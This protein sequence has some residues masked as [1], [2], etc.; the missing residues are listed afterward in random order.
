MVHLLPLPGS[1][2]FAGSFENAV[3]TAEADARTLVEAGFPAL[4]VENFGDAPFH[5]DSVPPVTIAAMTRAVSRIV[6]MGVTVGVNVLRNDAH[7]A[8]GIA[9]ATGAR[10][11]RVN[12]LTGLMY[13]DQGPIVGRAAELQRS[14]MSLAPDVEVW[15]DVMVKHASPPPGADI[16][17]TALDT[18][19]RGLADAVIVSGAGTSSALD[20]EEAALVKDSVPAGTRIVAGS[21]V[22]SSNLDGMLGSIDT[23]IVGS[24]LKVG[25]DPDNRP[26]PVRVRAFVELARERGLV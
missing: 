6:D 11:I 3:D 10:F 17:Q 8:L 14:R 4:I 25:G 23:F 20:P 24:S 26:D 9:A 5:A 19:E 2:L 15:A 1:P 13:T 22:D 7:A 18:V 21:G 12:V 16:G